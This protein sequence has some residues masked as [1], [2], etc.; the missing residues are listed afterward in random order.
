MRRYLILLFIFIIYPTTHYS[1]LYDHFLIGTYNTDYPGRLGNPNDNDPVANDY[2]YLKYI[3]DQ[4]FSFFLASREFSNPVQ[5]YT[6]NPNTDVFERADSLN[7]RVLNKIPELLLPYNSVDGINALNYYGSPPG[8]WGYNISDEPGL[9][10]LEELS[11]ICSDIKNYNNNLLTYINLLPRGV[12]TVQVFD[13]TP[14]IPLTDEEYIEYIDGFFSLETL[15]LI[16][17]DEYPIYK[18]KNVKFYMALQLFALKSVEYN[19]PFFYVG[20]PRGSQWTPTNHH[21][22]TISEFRYVMFS[23]IAYT[24]KGINY[25]MRDWGNTDYW[26]T[27]VDINVQNELSEIHEN[28]KSHEST[29][30]KLKF[31][32][33]FHYNMLPTFPVYSQYLGQEEEMLDGTDWN[34]FLNNS[35]EKVNYFG[36]NNLTPIVPSN[37][38]YLVNIAVTFN[39]DDLGNDYIWVLNKNI[40]TPFEGELN[41]GNN[42][43]NVVNILDDIICI[44]TSKVEFTLLP[45]ESKLFLL[46]AN[47]NEYICSTTISGTNITNIAETIIIGD[48]IS[49][50]PVTMTS[51]AEASYYANLIKLDGE[52]HIQN[53]AKIHFAP[54]DICLFEKSINEELLQDNNSSVTISPNP[55]SGLFNVLSQNTEIRMIEIWDTGGKLVNRIDN[56]FANTYTI[57][58]ANQSPGLFFVKI[59]LTNQRTINEKIIIE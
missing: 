18:G 6:S 44:G 11:E 4:N 31:I 59:N 26:D 41:F 27:F 15:D 53:N 9:Y 20:S 32:S 42:S 1:Q 40:T 12:N 39:Y 21:P 56:V 38:F 45:G 22:K 14:A 35:S 34:S 49:C 58:I 48:D 47:S 55:S 7:L 10:L 51:T 16:S 25:W 30:L 50:G 52:V 54:K 37:G 36:S 5:L 2:T 24:A 17:F 33:S 3:A 19:K 23:A 29:L 13:Q 8:L 43:L 46:N 28:L 57:D